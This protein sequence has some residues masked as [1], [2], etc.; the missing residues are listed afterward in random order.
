MCRRRLLARPAAAAAMA[1]RLEQ[2]GFGRAEVVIGGFLGDGGSGW[3]G[4]A[5]PSGKLYQKYAP[6]RPGK[7]ERSEKITGLRNPHNRAEWPQLASIGQLGAWL[8]A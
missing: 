3:L 2:G 8:G 6:Q 1:R 5:C 7:M 4:N